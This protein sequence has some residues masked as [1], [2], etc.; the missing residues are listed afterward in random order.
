MV[1]MHL[2]GTVSANISHNLNLDTT[3]LLVHAKNIT[4]L[5]FNPHEAL[6]RI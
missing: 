1:A 4:G 6:V 5:V 2:L 3:G